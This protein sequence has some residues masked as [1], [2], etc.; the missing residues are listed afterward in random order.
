MTERSPVGLDRTPRANARLD[1]CLGCQGRR[2]VTTLS[3]QDRQHSL[4]G[5]TTLCTVQRCWSVLLPGTS[6]WAFSIV[7]GQSSHHISGLKS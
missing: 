7:Q 5:A 4:A 3:Q 2:L 1:A 6:S